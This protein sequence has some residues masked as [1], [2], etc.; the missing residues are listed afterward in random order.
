MPVPT[1]NTVIDPLANMLPVNL[2]EAYPLVRDCFRARRVVNLISSPGVGK[3][4]L[5]KQIADDHELLVVDVRLST[6]DPT[7][8]N[9]F[10]HIWEVNGRKVA[11]YIPMD[12]FPVVG[13]ELPENPK[14]GKPYKGWI[15]FLDEFNA[16]TLLVQS[17]AYK[18]LLDRMVGMYKLDDRCVLA[19]AGNLMTDKA[20]TNRLSTATQSRVIHLPIKV[21][22]ETWHFWA[23]KVDID[24]RVNSFIKYR[25]K[26]L[27]RFDP[28]HTDLTFPCP[29]TWEFTSDL[30]KPYD[31]IPMEKMPLLAGTTGIGA[32]REFHAFSEVYADIPAIA[33]IVR[34]PAGVRIRDEPSVHHAMTGLIGHHMTE[35]NSKPC[36]QFLERLGADFQ[37]VAIRQAVGRN[38]DLMKAPALD[39]WLKHNTEEL[40]RRR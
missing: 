29:R 34:D 11:S 31:P 38:F 19:M 10:P 40:V 4:S 36:I 21:C 30:I 14:T 25:P 9:G 7:E 5:I 18:I 6:I 3:S 26:L 24:F 37:V 17:A 15:L 16:G 27:H 1:V 32:S 28:N 13:K 39:K 35:A 12:L 20:I 33:D 2:D 22:N 8:L 23:N